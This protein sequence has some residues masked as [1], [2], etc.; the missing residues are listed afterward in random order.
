VIS[1]GQATIK[2]ENDRSLQVFAG[3]SFVSMVL[4]LAVLHEDHLFRF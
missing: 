2:R 1:H 3:A 4:L